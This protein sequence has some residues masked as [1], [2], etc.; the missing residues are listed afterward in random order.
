[1]ISSIPSWL[2][3]ASLIP[4]IAAQAP[5]VAQRVAGEHG[6]GAAEQHRHGEQG[7]HEA[8]VAGHTGARQDHQ[9]PES[10]T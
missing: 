10:A 8:P 4:S 7:H 3:D 5:A 2:F 1:M 9:L 6:G